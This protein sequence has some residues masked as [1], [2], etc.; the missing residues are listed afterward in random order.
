MEGRFHE[1]EKIL[2]K[3]EGLIKKYA[4]RAVGSER[5]S[6]LL[7]YEFLEI[8]VMWI[9]GALGFAIRGLLLRLL[10]K[11]TGGKDYFSN[12]ITVRG[13]KKITIG[14]RV[15]I[16]SY[17]TLDVKDVKARGIEIGSGTF[18]ERFTVI[19][20][21]IGE[22]GYVRI[23]DNCSI[24]CSVNIFGHGGAVIG[25]NVMIA[26]HT[27]I[28]ASSHVFA[29]TE[30]PMFDQGHLSKGILIEDDVW[31]GAGSKILDGVKIGKGSIIGAG[32]VVT[33]DIEPYSIA[34]GVPARTI[35]K[36]K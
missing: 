5:I 33:G 24:G 1:D 36:R 18:V 35:R 4:R 26:S 14:S 34:V 13:G 22:N 31:L 29:D 7:L 21:G 9:P 3:K 2:T 8:F 25:N 32:S 11:K 27:C 20:S 23:G 19:S 15:F 16:D 10:F 30:R 12:H 28:I 6:D 17:V